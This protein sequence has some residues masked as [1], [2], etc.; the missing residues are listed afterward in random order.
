MHGCGVYEVNRRLMWGKYYFGELL[1][2]HH[3]CTAEISAMHAG[4]AEVAAAKARMFVNKPDG[5]VRELKGPYNDPQHPYMYEEED[6]WM[7]PGFINMFY[8]VP[9]FWKRYVH[10]VDQERE[11]WLNSFYKSPLRIPMP[12]ELEYW[13]SK[14]PEFMRIGNPENKEDELLLHVPTGRLINWAEDSEGRVRLFWQPAISDGGVKPKDVEFIPLGFDEF[15]GKTKEESES[16]EEKLERLLE[17]E[18]RSIKEKFQQKVEKK[19]KE[20]EEE[21]KNIE[22]EMKYIENQEKMEDAVE[23]MEYQ[24]ELKQIY[25]ELKER[26]TQKEETKEEPKDTSG[27]EDFEG[28]PSQGNEEAEEEENNADKKPR[29]F[30]TVA[31]AESRHSKETSYAK[32]DKNGRSLSSSPTLFASL[33]MVPQVAVHRFNPLVSWLKGKHIMPFTA[34]SLD[35]EDPGCGHW[36]PQNSR[37]I[38][39][40]RYPK[41]I[42]HPLSRNVVARHKAVKVNQNHDCRTAISPS[43]CKHFAYVPCVL[44]HSCFTSCKPKRSLKNHQDSQKRKWQQTIKHSNKLWAVTKDDIFSLSI[45]MEY[46]S[47]RSSE[48]DLSGS[49]SGGIYH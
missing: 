25:D 15:M 4:L 32:T 39:L 33:S 28:G 44:S 41:L 16:Q 6:L 19:K 12:A 31:F 49:F 22:L 5:M 24:F 30:G 11:M 7:A 20:W 43:P 36:R 38:T 3:E 18:K 13:W 34:V 47:C 9:D 10:D 23:E 17:E 29:S 1:S 26:V 35:L 14:D 46:F 21:R 40:K 8:E 37:S 48:F 45:P 27:P 42:N 2:N